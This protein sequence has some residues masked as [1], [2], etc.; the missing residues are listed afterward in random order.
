MASEKKPE[1]GGKSSGVM[2]FLK[3]N[4]LPLL[5]IAILILNNLYWM[6]SQNNQDDRFEASMTITNGQVNAINEKLTT[7]ETAQEEPEEET[8]EP[9]EEPAEEPQAPIVPEDAEGKVGEVLDVS[10]NSIKITKIERGAIM[11]N[12]PKGDLF[13]EDLIKVHFVITNNTDG[14]QFYESEDFTLES[15]SGRVRQIYN[16]KILKPERFQERTIT[17][18]ATI[19]GFVVFEDAGKSGTVVW[20]PQN[21]Q[22]KARISYTL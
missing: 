2:G 15:A 3:R 21:A 6:M 1:T 4:K 14:N 9:A 8:E 18:G 22:N 5:L 17:P 11:Y 20:A 19:N 16:S 12:T 7:E 13:N 10:G